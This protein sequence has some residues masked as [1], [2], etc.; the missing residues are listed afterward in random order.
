MLEGMPPRT[1]PTVRQE[2]VGIELRKMRDSASRTTAQAAALLGLDRTKITQIE[3]GYY[4]VNA[5]RIRALASDYEES[6]AEFIHALS[7]MAEERHRGWWVEYRGSVPAGFLDISE[8]EFFAQGMHTYQV[9][10]IPGVMQTEEYARAIFQD[11]YPPLSPR[12][13]EARVENR[14]QRSAFLMAEGA[15]PYTAVVHEAALRMRF[16]GRNA[17]QRQL[18]QLLTFSELPHV[19]LHV[20]TFEANGFKGAGQGIIYARGPLPRLDTLQLD[21]VG[22]P[23]FLHEQRQLENYRHILETMT[24]RSLSPGQSRDF[25]T[26]LKKEI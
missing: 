23:V 18:E 4:P 6:D 9:C 14:V 16:G 11:V 24:D 1:T 5:E 17:A 10:H 25:I 26:V 19:T 22:G 21:A 15:Q 13:L 20:L 8:M 12:L 7:R 2:R 3:K